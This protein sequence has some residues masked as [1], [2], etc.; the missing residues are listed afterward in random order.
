MT[1]LG[2]L[3]VT[4]HCLPEISTACAGV[5]LAHCHLHRALIACSVDETACRV[6]IAAL[7]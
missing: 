4:R 7:E 2:Y 3:V 6:S 1:C 5:S